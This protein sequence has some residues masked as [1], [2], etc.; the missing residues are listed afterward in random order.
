MDRAKSNGPHAS[1]GHHQP[2]QTTTAS[3]GD[4]LAGALAAAARGWHVFPC[5]SRRNP[6]APRDGWRWAEW[7]TTDPVKIRQWLTGTTVYGIAC[8]PSGLVVADLDMP[9]QGYKLPGGWAAEPG[10]TDGKDVFAALCELMGS[11]WPSTYAVVTPSGGWHLYFTADPG[12]RITV[13]VG[14]NGGIAPMVDIRGIGGYVVGPGSVVD[15]RVYETFHDT[16]PEPLPGWLA[17]ACER[18]A[19]QTSGSP[20]RAPY[21]QPATRRAAYLRAARDGEAA[22]VAAAPEGGR[23]AQLNK[24]AYKLAGY[25]ELDAGTI[26]AELTS[27]ARSAGLPDNEIQRTIR[28]ALTARDRQ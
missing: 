18:S 3:I 16:V 13:S 24:S 27:A 9:K 15:G 8:G 25:G 1:T 7:N 11:P 26:T 20:A 10:I 23:N 19:R 5:G 22:A 21:G 14:D 17:E 2:P 12:R 28:S 6:K 4:A